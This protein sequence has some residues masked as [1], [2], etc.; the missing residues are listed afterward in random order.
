MKVQE[1]IDRQHSQCPSGDDITAYLCNELRP[2]ESRQIQVH[3]DSCSACQKLAEEITESLKLLGTLE[4]MPTVP[5]LVPAVMERIARDILSAANPQYFWRILLSRRILYIA[6]SIVGVVAVIYGL[7]HIKRVKEHVV[8]A[9]TSEQNMV[10]I[11]KYRQPGIHW[12][13]KTQETDGRWDPV[14]W[15]GKREYTIGLTAISLLAVIGTEDEF[16]EKD[17]CIQRACEFLFKQQHED[18][19][20]GEYFDGTMYNHGIATFAL[21]EVY[22]KD[23]KAEF[24]QPLKFALAFI[25]QN[26]LAT[27]GWAY[28]TRSQEVA[29]TSISTWPL[30]ALLISHDIGWKDTD[31]SINRAVQWLVG[32]IDEQGQFGYEQRGS[33]PY[34]TQSLTAMGAYC[35]LKA[36]RIG[37]K[38]NS[39]IMEMAKQ[40]VAIVKKADNADDFYKTY[41]QICVFKEIG[42]SMRNNMISMQSQ[43]IARIRQIGPEKGS[44]DPVD[45]WGTTGGRIYSTAMALMS[46]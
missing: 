34:G 8:V 13:V 12:L 40:K 39:H 17:I 6:A 33:S 38:I 27:G 7:S 5:D 44:W 20:F 2:E 41:F 15:G 45:R 10:D 4:K 16:P 46:L 19:R 25:R 36:E 18:G 35:L 9:T 31:R 42:E 30:L 1:K 29:N 43:L 26:Q 23:K 32:L 14:R 11:T 22:R 24:E 3:I 28:F 37:I 21:L